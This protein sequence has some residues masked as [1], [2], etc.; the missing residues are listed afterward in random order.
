MADPIGLGRF[1]F[2]NWFTIFKSRSCKKLFYNLA[3]ENLKSIPGIDPQAVM[4]IIHDIPKED[5][6]IRGGQMADEIVEIR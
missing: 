3:V 4:I 1:N 5:W 2:K 6:G